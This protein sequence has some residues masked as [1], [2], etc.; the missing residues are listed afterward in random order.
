MGSRN[1]ISSSAMLCSSNF[2][3]SPNTISRVISVSGV[4]QAGELF[5][6]LTVQHS[7]VALGKSTT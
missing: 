4:A 5:D 6:T 1:T 7:S 3:V 2:A